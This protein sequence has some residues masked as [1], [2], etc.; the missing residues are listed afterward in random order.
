MHPPMLDDQG[1]VVALQSLIRGPRQPHCASRVALV[2]ERP[3]LRTS[4]EVENALYQVV[5][6]SLIN[7]QK[8][9]AGSCAEVRYF[10]EPGRLVLEIE[11]DG[12]GLFGDPVLAMSMGVG[13][14]GMRA[15][16]AH[17][18]GTLTLS[19]PEARPA[20]PRRSAG[21]RDRLVLQSRR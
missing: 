14:Q 1:L 9:A 10:R 19:S 5:Q 13:I 12:V 20:G 7:V 3:G 15:R 11:D 16:L 6:E 21:G 4:A 8:H 17:V 2:C 18:G